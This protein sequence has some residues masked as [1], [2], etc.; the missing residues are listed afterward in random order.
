MI[1]GP[2]RWSTSSNCGLSLCSK[3][4]FV[5]QG[6]VRYI[7][8][9]VLSSGCERDAER[10]ARSGCGGPINLGGY[11]VELALKNMEYKAIDDS[12]VKRGTFSRCNAGVFLK[13]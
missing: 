6:F 11:G 9:P 8:R 1:F 13:H 3:R 2:Y 7:V 5:L 4:L 10:C 12:D